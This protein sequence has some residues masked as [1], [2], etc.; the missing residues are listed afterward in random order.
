MLNAE[1][2]A[3]ARGRLRRI[4]GQVQGLQRMLENDAYCVDILLQISAVQGALEQ[5]QK[6]LLGRHI[7]SCVSDAM[8]SGSRGDR[9]QKIEEL[10][11]V[12]ARFGGR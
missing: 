10:L 4:E 11:D 6:L 8:R 12:F 2:K 7:E 3:K 9:Q 5:C 1:I